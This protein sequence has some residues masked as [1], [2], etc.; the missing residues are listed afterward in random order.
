MQAPTPVHDYFQLLGLYY[1]EPPL[2][3]FLHSI[4]LTKAPRVPRDD[5]STILESKSAG[6]EVTFTEE[7]FVE[8]PTRDYLDGALVL[9]CIHFHGSKTREHEKFADSLPKGLRFEMNRADVEQLLG[10][11]SKVNNELGSLRWDFEEHCMS[12]RFEKPTS[13]VR[14]S[15]QLHNR[16]TKN[17]S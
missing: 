3:E 1:G 4:N 11:P 6:M 2:T 12:V 17:S 13:I 8:F 10:T 9:S 5:T 7:E 15:I 14:V 16:Y